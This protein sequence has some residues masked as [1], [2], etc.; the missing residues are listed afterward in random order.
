LFFFLN[1]CSTFCDTFCNFRKL[2]RAIAALAVLGAHQPLLR[3]GALVRVAMPAPDQPPT[4]GIVVDLLLNGAVTVL[5]GEDG[6]TTNV[7]R[8]K[9]TPI[10]EMPASAAALPLD[11]PLLDALLAFVVGARAKTSLRQSS[12]GP[13][14]LW[15]TVHAQLRAAGVQALAV[16]LQSASAPSLLFERN[17]GRDVDALLSAVLATASCSPLQRRLANAA[18]LQATTARIDITSHRSLI[19]YSPCNRARARV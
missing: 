1:R 5:S 19:P 15:Q 4:T 2:Q 18:A 12:H 13:R 10:D 11:A 16:L 14:R 8:D 9:C 6:T 7:A 3:V 17:G